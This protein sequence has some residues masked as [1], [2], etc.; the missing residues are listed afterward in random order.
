MVTDY[1]LGAATFYFAFVLARTMGSHNRVSGWLWSAAFAAASI[2]AFVGGSFHGFSLALSEPTLHTMWS[3]I[4]YS[5]G[6]SFGLMVGGVHAA[7]IQKDDG[8]MK[9]LMG[10]IAISL[11]GL[12]VQSTGFRHDVD[13][14]HNDIFHVIQIM[15]F[16]H[17]FRFARL[18]R[19]RIATSE[20]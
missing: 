4:V 2:G 7:N 9:W 16:Y 11:V 17:L 5:V 12:I 1:L 14:N 6:T 19:D 10:G 8:S 18:L 13:F 3:V 20:R 15:A